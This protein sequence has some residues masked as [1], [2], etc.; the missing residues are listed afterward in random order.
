M[1]KDSKQS[2]AKYAEKITNINENSQQHSS[3]WKLISKSQCDI[4][5][6]QL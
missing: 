6:F 4:A 2:V 1:G 3:L 5:S